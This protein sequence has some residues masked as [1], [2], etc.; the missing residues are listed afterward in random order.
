MKL[1][2]IGISLG[3]AVLLCIEY[4]EGDLFGWEELESN[5]GKQ[6]NK[7]SSGFSKRRQNRSKFEENIQNLKFKPQNYIVPLENPK[8]QILFHLK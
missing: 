4:M 7:N 8:R 3:A 2:L 5:F 1:I 6:S